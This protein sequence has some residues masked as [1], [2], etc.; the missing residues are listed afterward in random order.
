MH[1]DFIKSLSGDLICSIKTLE[2][3]LFSPN[4]RK[5]L[6]DKEAMLRL[7]DDWTSLRLLNSHI[8]TRYQTCTLALLRHRPYRTRRLL[9]MMKVLILLV[10]SD[11]QPEDS[12]TQPLMWVP[13][14]TLRPYTKFQTTLTNT[15]TPTQNTRYQDLCHLKLIT[16]KWMKEH[17]LLVEIKH[18]T[19]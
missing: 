8:P 11:H 12:S 18:K 14:L 5:Y 4:L 15:K 6:Y 2:E 3:L 19:P 10:P 1:C 17:S 16:W 13:V 7:W 9:W